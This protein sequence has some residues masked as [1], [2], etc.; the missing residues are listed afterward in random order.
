MRSALAYSLSFSLIYG[1]P[2]ALAGEARA[3]LQPQLNTGGSGG[4]PPIYPPVTF[5]DGAGGFAAGSKKGG[6]NASGKPRANSSHGFGDMFRIDG[7]SKPIYY[8]GT[9]DA[10]GRERVWMY[11]SSDL[12]MILG[13][14]IDG[15]P[16]NPSYQNV[17]WD[18]SAQY[19]EKFRAGITKIRGDS[20]PASRPAAPTAKPGSAQPRLIEPEKPVAPPKSGKPA[21]SIAKYGGN[22]QITFYYMGEV[23]TNGLERVWGYIEGKNG[24][25][26]KYVEGV[27]SAN[28]KVIGAKP[29]SPPLPPATPKIHLPAVT[30]GVTYGNTGSGRSEISSPQTERLYWRPSRLQKTM[31]W[32][33]DKSASFKRLFMQIRNYPTFASVNG[34][35]MTPEQNLANMEKLSLSTPG[36]LGMGVGA[37]YAAMGMIAA[38]ELMMEYPNNPMVLEQYFENFDAMH[39]LMIGGF[40]VAAY[41]FMKRVQGFTSA[42][43]VLRSVPMFAAGLFAGAIGSVLVSMAADPDVQACTGVTAFRATFKFTQDLAACDAAYAKYSTDQLAV[44]LVPKLANLMVTGS[45]FLGTYFVINASGLAAA[46]RATPLLKG[47]KPG[48]IGVGLLLVSAVVWLS[49]DKISSTLFDTEKFVREN[50]VANDKVENAMLSGW[51]QLRRDRFADGG[52]KFSATLDAYGNMLA[53]W[54]NV[55]LAKTYEAYSQWSSKVSGYHAQL[56]AAY[57]LYSDF[58]ARIDFERRHPGLASYDA[59]GFNPTMIRNLERQRINGNVYPADPYASGWEVS[60]GLN[61]DKVVVS[62]PLY[63]QDFTGTWKYI[64]TNGF[65]DYIVTSMACGP[66]AEGVGGASPIG[67]FFAQ[68]VTHNTS[69]EKVVDNPAGQAILFQPPRLVKNLDGTN[70]SVCESPLTGGLFPLDI[71]STTAVS[72]P[73][74][75]IVAAPLFSNQKSYRNLY[76]Y[77]KDNVR[78]TV[79]DDSRNDFDNWW[80]KTVGGP[81]MQTEKALRAEYEQMLQST[82]RPAMLEPSYHWC[83]EVSG[84]RPAF[85]RYWQ[86]L[87]SADGDTCDASRL[88]RLSN[89]LIGSLRDELRL[90]LAMTLEVYALNPTNA[91]SIDNAARLARGILTA[92][93]R[94]AAGATVIKAADRPS[95]DVLAQEAIDRFIAFR[96]VVLATPQSAIDSPERQWSVKLLEKVRPIFEQTKI[97]YTILTA[98]EASTAVSGE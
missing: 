29:F 60:L 56:D 80:I 18:R 90:Y 37:F 82:Y 4:K 86:Q 10:Q 16:A 38:Y 12:R 87:G 45:L 47:A 6:P 40:M 24:A 63:T 58:V 77:I 52:D 53:T 22:G 50:M 23:T 97:F 61:K 5:A 27:L 39:V 21:G 28:G 34:A 65:F 83:G 75:F 20:A 70:R 2:L 62:D 98:F 81:V 25:P 48:L 13:G 74:Q 51:A 35:E 1:S 71:L 55:Q 44:Q 32:T 41:P 79:L 72:R 57:G 78:T 85:S 8:D 33:A 30:D 3:P 14:Y 46:L 49:A 11:R 43:N 88:H 42:G 19:S 15:N 92:F 66:E 7:Q 95:G 59:R 69:P 67:A 93:D 26:G 54:R 91:P 31:R 9:L 76:D 94:Y 36:Q 64:S 84:Q 96:D 73:D 68:W 17:I 89:G